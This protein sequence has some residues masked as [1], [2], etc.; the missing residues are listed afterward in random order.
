MNDSCRH[1]SLLEMLAG[2]AL[3]R[4]LESA[5]LASLAEIA[6]PRRFG[7]GEILFAA[8]EPAVGFFVVGAGRVRVYVLSPE[9]K[10]Q[11]LHSFGPGEPVGEAAVFA[12]QSYPAYAA[13]SADSEVA[14]IPRDGFVKL[15]GR[16]PEV[17]LNMLATLSQRLRS[18]AKKIEDLSLRDVTS[19]LARYLLDH[20]AP[21]QGGLSRVALSDSKSQLAISLGTTPESLSRSLARLKEAGV[22]TVDRR[23]VTVHDHKQL[24]AIAEGGR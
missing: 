13:A 19:R 16:R 1:C 14:Y 21:G 6:T 22:I 10:E 8:G 11:T 24:A 7:K 2:S 12:G 4:G 17:A 5:D 20:A 18:F 15:I 3:F 9:G 23:T